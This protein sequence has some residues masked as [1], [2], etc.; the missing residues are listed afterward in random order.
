VTVKSFN[1]WKV[2][3]DREVSLRRMRDEEEKLK[4]MTAKEKEEYKR[5]GARL[6]G[7]LVTPCYSMVAN[8]RSL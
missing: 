5:M 1:E 3:F 6:T 2:K 7:E 4:A 8:R